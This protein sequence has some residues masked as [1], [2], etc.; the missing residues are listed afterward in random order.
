MAEKEYAI[1]VEDL[2]V[3]YDVKPVLWDCD[4]KFEKGKLTAIVGPNGAGK[5]TMIKAIM[6]LLKP[7][8]G[9]IT[10]NGQHQKDEY[11]NIAYVPQSGSVDW[12][13]PATVEDIVLMGRYGH[14][15]WIKRPRKEDREIA[16]E[17]LERVGMSAY[18]DRQI[19][20][21]SG[22]QQQRVFLARALT[23]QAEIYILDEPLKGVDVKTEEILMTLLKELAASGKTVIVVHHDLTSIEGYFD[24]IALVNV[25]LVAWGPVQNTF[26]QENLKLTYHTDVGGI[27]KS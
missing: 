5:S 16:N 24:N 9:K 13:F 27:V 7:I 20:Q 26:T 17:M 8:S 12:D 22:G 6:G 15:G 21:L 3:T 18:R 23:Q 2:T 4:V 10:I 25:K 19:S 11:K 1:E 14:I